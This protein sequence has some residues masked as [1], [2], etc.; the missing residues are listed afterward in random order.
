MHN[1]NHMKFAMAVHLL[2]KSNPATRQVV[3]RHAAVRRGPMHRS[4]DP[5]KRH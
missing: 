1:A 4:L 5:A 3:R 2:Q